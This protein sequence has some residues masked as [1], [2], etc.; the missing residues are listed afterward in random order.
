MKMTTSNF[1]EPPPAGPT[2]ARNRFNFCF[3]RK[4]SASASMLSH[5]IS[6]NDYSARLLIVISCL[7]LPRFDLFR[8]CL[9]S[10]AQLATRL[11]ITDR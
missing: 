9:G 10:T 2:T 5:W 6:Q 8:F 3:E 4:T 7:G 1:F 11:A